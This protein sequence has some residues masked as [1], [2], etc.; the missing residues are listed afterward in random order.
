MAR[1]H[2]ELTS[3]SR[4]GSPDKWA[5]AISLRDGRTSAASESALQMLLRDGRELSDGNLCD[6]K[7]EKRGYNTQER[8]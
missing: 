5:E 8:R 6:M 7:I 3:L 4:D 1:L 2:R